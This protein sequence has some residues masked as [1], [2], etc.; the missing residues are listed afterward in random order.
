MNLCIFIY[1]TKTNNIEPKKQQNNKTNNK[2]YTKLYF[3]SF[4]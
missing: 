2:K 4:K 1:T 3:Q